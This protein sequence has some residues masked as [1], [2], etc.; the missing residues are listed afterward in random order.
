MMIE[1]MTQRVERVAREGVARG[2][3]FTDWVVLTDIGI[4]YMAALPPDN[5]A[6]VIGFVT[7]AFISGYTDGEAAL[8]VA[9]KKMTAE[10]NKE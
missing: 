5:R 10:R 1:T 7:R 2:Q 4:K 6:A 9:Y 3:D 8:E